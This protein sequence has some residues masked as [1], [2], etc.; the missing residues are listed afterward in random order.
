MCCFL[1]GSTAW[2]R[3]GQSEQM[4]NPKPSFPRTMLT[5]RKHRCYC[6]H[7]HFSVWHSSSDSGRWCQFQTTGLSGSWSLSSFH[8][9]LHSNR[10]KKVMF[11][12]HKR[13]LMSLG[14]DWQADIKTPA[15]TPRLILGDKLSGKRYLNSIHSV[16]LSAGSVLFSAESGQAA[17]PSSGFSC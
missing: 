16:C 9:C 7:T 11:S 6:F 10:G 15:E 4:V 3:T 1:P 14:S 5:C 12:L 2:T 17:G 13:S 8:D